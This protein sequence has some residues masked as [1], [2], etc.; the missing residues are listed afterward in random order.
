[1]TQKGLKAALVSL[2]RALQE[3]DKDNHAA[4]MIALHN[5]ANQLASWIDP[6]EEEADSPF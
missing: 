5:V 4:V 2:T 3:L 6:K 1:M